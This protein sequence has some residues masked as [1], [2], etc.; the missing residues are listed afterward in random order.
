[1]RPVLAGLI[2]YESLL[3]GTLDLADLDTLNELL[4][5]REEND[6]RLHAAAARGGPH[7]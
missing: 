7:G 1:M 6:R 2:R 3:D 4:D 5:V